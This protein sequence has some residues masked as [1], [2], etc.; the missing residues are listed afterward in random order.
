MAPSTYQPLKN[1]GPKSRILDLPPE[2]RNNI[3]EYVAHSPTEAR[4][5]NRRFVQHPLACTSRQLQ[6]EFGPVFQEA[7]THAETVTAVVTDFDFN[8]LGPWLTNFEQQRALSI[9]LTLAAPHIEDMAQLDHWMQLCD[10]HDDEPKTVVREY[11]AVLT[12]EDDT[13]ADVMD[14]RSKAVEAVAKNSHTVEGFVV[15]VAIIRAQREYWQRK[16][17]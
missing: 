12:T 15:L 1:L 4:I 2:L 5:R 3:Y 6:L 11:R 13:G 7:A 14:S 9:T 10:E 17:N 16:V 8:A